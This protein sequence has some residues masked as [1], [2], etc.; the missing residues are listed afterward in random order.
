MKGKGFKY[1]PGHGPAVPQQCPETGSGWIMGGPFWSQ[2]IHDQAW[3]KGVLANLEV[4]IVTCLLNSHA[5][6]LIT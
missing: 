5:Y 2:P 4:M 3:V 6:T 1:A